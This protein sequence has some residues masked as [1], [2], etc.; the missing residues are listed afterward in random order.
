MK[1]ELPKYFYRVHVKLEDPESHDHL[2]F[3]LCILQV[4]YSLLS[5]PIIHAILIRYG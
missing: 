2:I 3:D 5:R 1:R 4:L